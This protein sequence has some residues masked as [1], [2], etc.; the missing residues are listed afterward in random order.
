MFLTTAEAEEISLL[1][2]NGDSGALL[3][4]TSVYQGPFM[5]R[6]DKNS[7]AS[8]T[9][10]CDGRFVFVPWIADQKLWVAA[11][12]LNGRL[13][14]KAQAGPF[15]SQ[16][17]YAASPV[18]HNDLVIVAADNSGNAVANL[19]AV[20]SYMA[21]LDA[22]SGE[23]RWRVRR[24]PHASYGTPVVGQVAGRPQ[25][26]L[27][28]HDRISAYDPSTGRELWFCR[29]TARRTANT[30]AFADN[31]VVA[32]A[33]FEEP[34]VVC[35]RGD[36]TGDVTDKLLWTVRRGATDVPSPLVHDGHVYLVN[37]RGVASCI[38]LDGGD[39][40]WQERLEGAFSASPTRVGRRIY[41]TNE[42]G[43]TYVFAA[44][45]MFELLATNPLGDPVF[46]SPVPHANGLLIRGANF[47]WR[48]GPPSETYKTAA[49]T[50]SR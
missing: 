5:K 21:A 13:R 34:Q 17:G 30:I 7:Q 50:K 42:D 36:G 44:S 40:A 10:A 28:G 18:C 43:T 33:T 29:W 24:I 12:E 31:H 48:L 1:C 15:V 22:R 27:A 39:I 23:V 11:V 19:A 8:A 16:W 4:R 3:W 25:L 9:P 41:A 14:W 46:A 20:T 38:A 26:L 35:V 32:S 49:R 6:H 45:P 47:L 2:F 37:D